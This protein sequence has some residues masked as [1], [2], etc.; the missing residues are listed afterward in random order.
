[1]S[2]LSTLAFALLVPAGLAT[3]ALASLYTPRNTNFSAIGPVTITTQQGVMNCTVTF[4]GVTTGRGELEFINASFN[5]SEDAC[6]ENSFVGNPYYVPANGTKR[7]KI[8]GVSGF[9]SLLGSCGPGNLPFVAG[10]T[11]VWTLKKTTLPGGC[12]VSGSV[13]TSPAITILP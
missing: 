10:K 1:M 11:G 8:L 3:P 2:R 5:G 4:Q 13:T 7:G 12:T 6:F 9:G